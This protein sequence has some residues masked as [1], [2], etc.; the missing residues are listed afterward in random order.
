MTRRGCAT[1]VW[2]FL[3]LCAAAVT[4]HAQTTATSSRPVKFR[5]VAIAESGNTPH[6]DFVAAAKGRRE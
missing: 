2:M 5:V 4:A 6:N 1:K 3:V